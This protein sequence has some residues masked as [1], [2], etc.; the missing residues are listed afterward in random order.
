MQRDGVYLRSKIHSDQS[1]L[2]YSFLYHCFR[3]YNDILTYMNSTVL[4]LFGPLLP[5]DKIARIAAF[6]HTCTLVHSARFARNKVCLVI[7]L[8]VTGEG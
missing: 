3:L 5:R 4:Q 8:T 2:T 1:A 6:G 7:F